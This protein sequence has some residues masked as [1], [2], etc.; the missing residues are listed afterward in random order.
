VIATHSA[1]LAVLGDAE[2][3]IRMYAAGGRGAPEEPGAVDRPDTRERVCQ[4]L[5]G[6]REASRRRGE[7]YGFDVRPAVR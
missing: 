1:N 7:R 5:E 2:L 3:V 6:G 4:L